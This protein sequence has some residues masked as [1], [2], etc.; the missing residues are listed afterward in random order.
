MAKEITKREMKAILKERISTWRHLVKQ[1][2]SEY[3]VTMLSGYCGAYNYVMTHTKQQI[4]ERF[5]GLR[6]T[7]TEISRE[8]QPSKL[9]Y[10]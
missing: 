8:C 9:R 1:E 6:I 5:T 7:F 3:N 2:E 10:I 4:R